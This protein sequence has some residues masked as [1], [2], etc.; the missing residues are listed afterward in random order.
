MKIHF[1]RRRE[2]FKKL[3]VFWVTKVMLTIL[4][5][6]ITIFHKCSSSHQIS[7]G[8][9]SNRP[10]QATAK[11]IYD[12]IHEFYIVNGIKFDF[13]ILGKTTNHIN[14]VINGIINKTNKNN[15]P[16]KLKV[17]NDISNSFNLMKHAVLFM[18]TVETLIDWH[19]SEN[20]DFRERTGIEK[21][22][23]LIYIEEIIPLEYLNQLQMRMKNHHSE[24]QQMDEL[25]FIVNDRNSINLGANVFYSELK[26]EFY[27][28]KSL[29]T[30]DL[31][32]QKWTKKLKI[33]DQG[34]N[35]HGCIVNFVVTENN[36]EL[37]HQIVESIAQK[38]NFTPHFNIFMT[39]RGGQND[40][41]EKLSNPIYL[42]ITSHDSSQSLYPIGTHN[43]YFLIS[44]NG[45]YSNYE[46]L[47]F[48]F[49]TTTWFLVLLTFGLTVLF[50][51]VLDLSPEWLRT[52]FVGKGIKGPGYN[53]I[54]IFMGISQ[55]KLPT[56][57]FCRNILL[58]YIWFCLIIRTCWQS[59]MFE[60]MTSDMRKPLPAS[61]EDLIEMNYAIIL[62]DEEKFPLYHIID[63]K[64]RPNMLFL[65]NH[66]FLILYSQA[67]FE[68]S[69]VKYAFFV[70]DEINLALTTVYRTSLPIMENEK[71]TR[72][73]SYKMFGNDVLSVHFND[74][75]SKFIESGITRSLYD[76]ELWYNYRPSDKEIKD[77]RR[78]LSMSDLEFGFMIFAG[79][80][81]LAFAVFM[82]EINSL[83]CRRHFR[84]FVGLYEFLRLIRARSRDYHDKW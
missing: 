74:M 58:I 51:F 41:T 20:V 31:K 47:L 43:F 83:L 36:K 60:F 18:K 15:F 75:I 81:L 78:I 42:G 84:K 24:Q 30:F 40:V 19:K 37:N 61:L 29:N 7:V 67:I 57:T 73:L 12:V 44:R 27:H 62:R 21:K 25:F 53:A 71:I 76:F 69:S 1:T 63:D 35:F 55:L 38:C 54:A 45:F 52:A 13:I 64:I 28:L 48:P 49:D 70:S 46:K 50:I 72:T 3:T 68:T 23:I 17:I 4:L 6:L 2:K 8:E 80:L 66:E 82:C 10:V 26:C 22:K 34:E 59:K 32:T 79:F 16:I 9:Y 65:D 11:A 77:T 33:F 39:N 14:D 5:F 56:E